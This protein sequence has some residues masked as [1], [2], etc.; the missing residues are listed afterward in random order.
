MLKTIAQ[1]QH[2]IG[3]RSY[4]FLCDN[5][6][7]LPEIKESLCQFIAYVNNLEQQAKMAQESHAAAQQEQAPD[8]EPALEKAE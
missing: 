3:E 1:L 4:T 2:M 6:S 7:P 8:I 5:T